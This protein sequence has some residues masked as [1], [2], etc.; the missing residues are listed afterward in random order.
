L[1]IWNLENR[2]TDGSFYGIDWKTSIH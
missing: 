2:K 1:K